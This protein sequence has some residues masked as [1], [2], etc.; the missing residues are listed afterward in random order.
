MIHKKIRIG[1]IDLKS[2]IVLPP[3][4]T[5]KSVEGKPGEALIAHYTQYAMNPMI[6]LI[7]TE[8]SYV[9]PQGKADP[10]QVSF[11]SEDVISAQTELTHA[12]HAANPE[13]KI[14]A[15]ISHA[16]LKTSS[17]VTGQELVSASA[18]CGK[19]GESRALS[20]DEIHTLSKKFAEAALRVK[21]SGYDGVE[22]HAAHTYLLNQFY[23][24]LT[25][26]RKDEYGAECLENRIRFLVETVRLVRNTVGKD[27]P[28]AVRLGGCD[29]QAGGN[30]IEDAVA[31]SKILEAEGIDLIDLSGG[32]T[33]GR[34]SFIR[35]GHSEPGYFSDMSEAAKKEVKIPVLVTGGVKTAQDAEKLLT[36]GKADLVGVG[37]ALLQ[38]PRWECATNE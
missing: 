30:T 36:E 10:F 17:D 24:P 7:I 12:V 13:V 1:N 5:Q 16:G 19:N 18:L 4:A 2:R 22:I 28:L 33:G 35:E 3:M 21:E 11:A 27:F 20:V 9:D 31:A 29:Y 15:Q 32:N 8:H 23:S 25:N 14:F 37:R 34:Y 38:D 26:F 6:G